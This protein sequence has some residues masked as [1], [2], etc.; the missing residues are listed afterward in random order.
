MAYESCF[1]E[2]TSLDIFE[3]VTFGATSSFSHHLKSTNT[4]GTFVTPATLE[5][6]FDGQ[7]LKLEFHFRANGVSLP[8]NIFAFLITADQEVLVWQDLTL[9]CT[10]PGVSIFPGNRFPL[11]K[12]ELKPT[13]SGE[14]R[15]LHL[16]VWGHL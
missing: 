14:S 3:G 13:V 12:I 6:S 4:N 2:Q 8:Y 5:G 9:G 1:P 7:A 10:G 11:E 15:I 16:I